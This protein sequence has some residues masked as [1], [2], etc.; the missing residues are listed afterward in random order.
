[1]DFVT[2]LIGLSRNKAS[3]TGVV[4]VPYKKTG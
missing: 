1:M 2:V 3:Y 4:G